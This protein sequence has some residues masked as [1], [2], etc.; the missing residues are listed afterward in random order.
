MQVNEIIPAVILLLR[1]VE[2]GKITGKELKN[3]LNTLIDDNLE[4]DI[5]DVAGL[6][7]SLLHKF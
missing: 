6:L 4:F 5:K 1:A 2:D 3:V 7:K